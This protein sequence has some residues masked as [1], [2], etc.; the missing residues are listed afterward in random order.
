MS[1]HHIIA[2]GG[3]GQMVA[4]LYAN[5]FLT[6]FIREPFRLLVVDTDQLS[7][8]LARLADF[9]EDV[10]R[11]AG[12]QAAPQIAEIEYLRVS[13]D[14]AGSVEEILT[15]GQDIAINEFVHSVQAFFAAE[16]RKQSVKEGLFARPALSAV[17][18]PSK[19]WE[20][21]RHIPKGARIGVVSSSIGG[22]GGGL[23]LP[24][25]AYLQ[26]Q[27]DGNYQ[28]RAVFMGQ[29]FKPDPGVK[30]D[31]LETFKSNDAFFHETRRRLL[32]PLEH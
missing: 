28:I 31:Q 29:Y 22:T 7:P 20:R 15:G 16:D 10:R 6:G 25:I 9:F 18:S 21:L 8:S 30:T 1:I 11:A 17:L 27:R 26:N 13:S 32:K 12:P 4:H 5:L 23:T 14:M 19:L 24:V 2:I 3:S